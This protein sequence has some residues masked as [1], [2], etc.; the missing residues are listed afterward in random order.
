MPGLAGRSTMKTIVIYLILLTTTPIGLQTI[1]AASPDK[2]Q[3]RQEITAPEAFQAA[4]ADVEHVYAITNRQVAKYDRLTGQRI[5]ISHGDAKHL[6]SG[7]FWQASL[8]CA[9]SNYPL[10]PEQSEIKVLDLE[11]MELSTLKNFGDFGGSLVWVV[12]HN[13]Y[14]WCNFAKYG[15]EN[16]ETFLVQFDDGW[17]ELQRWTY[18]TAV[19][20]QLGRYS[21]SGGLWYQNELLVTGHDKPE[22]YRLRLPATGNVLQFIGQQSVPFS[23]QGFAVDPKTGGLVG[24]NR[25]DRKIIFVTR[26]REA[27]NQIEMPKRGVC[28]HR[29]ASDTHPEN[30]L[31]A[32]REAIRLGTHMIEFD[33]AFSRDKKLVLL[34]DSTVNRTTDGT[35]ALSSL[36]LK[37][38]KQLD[39]GTWKHKRFAGERIPT[40]DEALAMMPQNIW[41][42]VH[43]KGNAELAQAVTERIVATGRL[44]QAFLACGNDA[45]RAAK[46]VDARI[47]ICNMERQ[48]NSQNY[49]DETIAMK[50]D[51][52]QLLGGKSVAPNQIKQLK[53]ESIRINFCC[54]NEAKTL[55]T[56]LEA[57]VEF[58]LVDRLEPMLKVADQQGI[59]RLRPI[60]QPPKQQPN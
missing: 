19:T 48:A 35:G 26:D 12:R 16:A 57:G 32:F 24:I 60:Y 9:H 52:I 6:N 8:L 53:Q 25:A 27:S 40:L 49:V 34:H 1:F 18:P 11:S 37:A 33:V 7:V 54:V 56:F 50:A 51:F 39:A 36:T 23:G 28:A 22:L 47:Q 3:Q 44:H 29:G 38:L 15:N 17:N 31:A 42:N 30:T 4:A 20:S 21:L 45:A 13:D 2:W 46:K 58:P 41:L 10:I 55:R 43:L 59:A 5:A 14:W